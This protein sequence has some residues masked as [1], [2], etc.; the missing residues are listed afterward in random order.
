MVRRPEEGPEL[1]E[2]IKGLQDGNDNDG[3]DSEK[4]QNG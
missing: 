1:T 2:V 4:S 3:K